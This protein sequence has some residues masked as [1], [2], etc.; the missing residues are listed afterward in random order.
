MG[1]N[2]H[3]S[4]LIPINIES[5][6]LLPFIEIFQCKEGSFPVK[7]LGIPLHFDRLTGWRARLL[8]LAAK[9][10]LI[11][12]CLSSIPIYLLSFF[13]FPKW[14]LSLL[15]TQLA[16]LLWKDEEGNHKIHLANWPSVCMK[17][18]LGGM[19]IPNL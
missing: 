8:S 15:D 10:I 7:Y 9:R 1:I 5:E 4:E 18:E 3:K 2:F 6:E 14:A 13:Q 19:G 16:N 17:K 12:A 11:Q